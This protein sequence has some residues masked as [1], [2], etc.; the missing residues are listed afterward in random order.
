MAEKKGN[1]V[2]LLYDFPTQLSTEVFTS[3]EWNRTTC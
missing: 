1:T 3:G 2:K